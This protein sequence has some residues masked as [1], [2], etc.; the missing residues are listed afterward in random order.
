MNKNT[1]IFF[2]ISL[3]TLTSCKIKEKAS[4]LNYLQNAEQLATEVSLKNAQ[5]TLQIGDQINIYVTA[6][7]MDVV[8]PFNQTYYSSQNTPGVPNSV[9]QATE[10]NYYVDSNGDIEFP[11]LGK[12]N[13][14]NKT[15]EQLKEELA[16]GISAY[17][18]NPTVL[19][20]LANLKVSVLGEVARPNQYLMTEANPTLLNALAAAGDFTMYGKR[21]DVLVVRNINGEI[22]QQRINFLDANF[23]N[24]PYFFLK[25]GDVIYVSAT[26]TKEK[27]ARVNPNTNT[28]I[29]VAGMVI[30][31]AGIFITI[32]KK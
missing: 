10:K 18:K 15:L 5:N 20:R 24:S 31:L 7:N 19:V 29:A 12:I 13:T 11:I 22:T 4:D 3:F 9:A 1:Y 25:Q 27:V 23:I 6:K 21:D 32:F 14:T 26:P 17:V 2:I 16:Q 28:Y 8:K 30:G